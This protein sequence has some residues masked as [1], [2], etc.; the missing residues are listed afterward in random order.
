MFGYR[1][2]NSI[3]SNSGKNHEILSCQSTA[4]YGVEI[5]LTIPGELVGHVY[6]ADELTVLTLRQGGP[7]ALVYMA[8]R[9]SRHGT[10]LY[11]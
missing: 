7:K 3:I 8:M 10:H 2:G 4:R 1:I 11:S 5:A 9:T 6:F